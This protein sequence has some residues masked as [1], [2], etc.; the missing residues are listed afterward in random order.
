[1]RAGDSDQLAVKLGRPPASMS[2]FRDLTAEQ[3]GL[4]SDAIDDAAAAHQRAVDDA[5]TAALPPFPRRLLG[6][7]L[8]IADGRAGRTRNGSPEADR[9]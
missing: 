9:S 8:R 4:L 5:Y 1:M 7:I 6:W 2:A 3:F